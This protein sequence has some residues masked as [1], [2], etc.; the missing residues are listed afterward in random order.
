MNPFSNWNY[1]DDVYYTSLATQRNAIYS[2]PAQNEFEGNGLEAF[3]GNAG[4]PEPNVALIVG[5]D[6]DKTIVY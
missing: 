1:D 6:N 5:A 2:E 4:C 3:F